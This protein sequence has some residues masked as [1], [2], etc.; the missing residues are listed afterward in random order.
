M[1]GRDQVSAHAY[2]R[3]RCF[4]TRE[5]LNKSSSAAAESFAPAMQFRKQEIHTV[6]LCFLNF[7]LGQNLSASALAD[8]IRA[9][10][11]FHKT[12]S[13]R[14]IEKQYYA[15]QTPSIHF[16]LPL[17]VYDANHTIK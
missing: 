3:N 13:N 2:G 9:S 6:F 1:C 8:L 11:V 12:V 15:A 4:Y 10:L 7:Y 14:F 16:L 17:A 5:P